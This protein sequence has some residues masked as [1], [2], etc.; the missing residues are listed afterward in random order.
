MATYKI[1]F[2]PT[3]ITGNDGSSA[4]VTGRTDYSNLTTAGNYTSTLNPTHTVSSNQ[5]IIEVGVMIKSGTNGTPASVQMGFYDTSGNKLTS[6]PLQTLST[7]SSA[8]PTTEAGCT[9]LTGLNLP[10]SAGDVGK[11]IRLALGNQASPVRLFYKTVVSGDTKYIGSNFP[12]SLS[13]AANTT[14]H[15]VA[16][17]VVEDIPAQSLDTINSSS[18][19]PAIVSGSNTITTTGLNTLT[20]VTVATTGAGSI[21]CSTSA[22]SGDGTFTMPW[23]PADGGSYPYFGSVNETATDGTNSVTMSTGTWSVPSGYAATTQTSV[24]TNDNTYLG[25]HIAGLAVNDRIYYSTSNGLVISS[26]G[27]VEAIAAMTTTVYVHKASDYKVY[28]YEM[29]IN[30]S[31]TLGGEAQISKFGVTNYGLASYGLTSSGVQ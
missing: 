28:S 17:F 30:E 11:T 10:F 6:I 12:S 20:S 13:G 14:T 19:N 31:G 18:S 8:T 24:V 16:W 7:S 27:Y 9:I 25:Y 2:I 26:N 29:T 15:N 21:V 23:P 3:P 1:G 4:T 22:P 5:R